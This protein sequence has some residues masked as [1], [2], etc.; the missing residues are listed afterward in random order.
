MDFMADL[1]AREEIKA[2]DRILDHL[3]GVA[4]DMPKGGVPLP[5]HIIEEVH[6]SFW[7]A[8][9]DAFVGVYHCQ[10]VWW[11]RPL[12][13]P[14]L[15]RLRSEKPESTLQTLKK[16]RVQ[17]IGPISKTALILQMLMSVYSD[18][19]NGDFPQEDDEPEVGR[20]EMVEFLQGWAEDQS[21]A[22]IS[23]ED[24]DGFLIET[25]A[26]LHAYGIPLALSDAHD[27]RTEW[28]PRL[29]VG[30]TPRWTPV[31]IYKFEHTWA[32]KTAYPVGG[33]TPY[34]LS[35]GP[36]SLAILIGQVTFA[37]IAFELKE[38]ERWSNRK[39][40]HFTSGWK[41]A[42][43]VPIAHMLLT[44]SQD[45]ELGAISDR[46]KAALQWLEDL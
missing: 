8:Q 15:K 27:G 44:V 33:V 23:E 10:E 26:F 31:E 22:G 19:R 36:A 34:R 16:E 17:E 40:R 1:A 14:Q 46:A 9:E 18:Y 7:L 5:C 21:H 37:V 32:Y 20:P 2:R 11:A 3:G 41:E 29:F 30:V 13:E 28:S 39:V 43:S 38:M 24:F 12:T 45:E 6:N 25:Q 42:I 4:P 35:E